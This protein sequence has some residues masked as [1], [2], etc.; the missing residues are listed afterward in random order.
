M[1]YGNAVLLKKEEKCSLDSTDFWK[2]KFSGFILFKILNA[3]KPTL[4]AQLIFPF[5]LGE[6]IKELFLDVSLF[7]EGLSILS[8]SYPICEDDLPKFSFCGRKKGGKLSGLLPAEAQEQE[9]AT[10]VRTPGR[11]PGSA[12]HLWTN[13]TYLTVQHLSAVS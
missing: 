1:L 3:A 6:D 12:P 4:R 7:S 8:Y 11:S 13:F 10:E 2:Q 5:P 9:L